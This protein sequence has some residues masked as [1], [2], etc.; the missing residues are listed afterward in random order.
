VQALSARVGKSSTDISEIISKNSTTVGSGMDAIQKVR[1]TLLKI[2]NEISQLS[3]H[4]EC[5]DVVAA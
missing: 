1:H 3:D 2:D 5:L 4:V